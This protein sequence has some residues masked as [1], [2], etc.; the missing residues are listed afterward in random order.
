MGKEWLKG[1]EKMGKISSELKETEEMKKGGA[2]WEV[3][4]R[5]A[6]GM[7]GTGCS[8]GIKMLWVS[9]AIFC[10]FTFQFSFDLSHC[11]FGGKVILEGHILDFFEIMA[12]SE[13]NAAYQ[14]PMYLVFAVWQLPIKWLLNTW[15]VENITAPLAVLFWDKLLFVILFI[16][17]GYCI[18]YI[19]Q[20]NTKN[21]EMAHDAQ[22]AYLCMP[23]LFM[24]VICMGMY[25][26][27]YMTVFLLALCFYYQEWDSKKPILWFLILSGISI[28]F[29]PMPLFYIPALLLLRQKNVLKLI[30]CI[31]VFLIPY[32]LSCLPFLGSPA[33]WGVINFTSS[34]EGYFGL[35][36]FGNISVS[37]L[38]M[39]AAYIYCY[40][41]EYHSMHDTLAAAGCISFAMFALWGGYHPQWFVVAVPFLV[42][43][44]CF[45]RNRDVYYILFPVLSVLFF[46]IK[47]KEKLIT[48]VFESGIWGPNGLNFIQIYD[49]GANMFSDTNT[50][51]LETIFAGI[52]I[53]FIC[54]SV[55]SLPDASGMK[56]ASVNHCA[57]MIVLYLSMVFFSA[58]EIVPHLSFVEHAVYGTNVDYD[59]AKIG[60]DYSLIYLQDGVKISHTL[61]FLEEHM[62]LTGMRLRPATWSQDY[63]ESTVINIYLENT[64]TGEQILIK[65]FPA[66]ELID[67][68]ITEI[69]FDSVSID[70][71]GI[72]ELIFEA[73]GIGSYTTAFVANTQG[74][75]TFVDGNGCGLSMQLEVLGKKRW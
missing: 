60:E 14:F 73:D 16:I 13:R 69:D 4:Y 46:I 29:K 44:Y 1:K 64:Q 36:A 7:W 27:I 65:S 51:M 24:I 25:D 10:F 63:P 34:G 28:C 70:K 56:K 2:V 21:D 61:G 15:E 11:A 54:D 57:P 49:G 47:D 22:W 32:V 12:E 19:V 3:M 55:N 67:A 9:A 41:K 5:T 8:A 23:P 52:L 48:R 45:S 66:D 17:S 37:F 43:T 6:A 42:F 26:A 62:V 72:Y 68:M 53:F 75:E 30:Q 74:T 35:S 31:V 58:I 20:K 18:K 39:I 40:L 33:F 38:I 71:S 59:L 50:L